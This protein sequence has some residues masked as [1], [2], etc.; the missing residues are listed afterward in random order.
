MQRVIEKTKK[1]SVLIMIATVALVVG[2]TAVSFYAS[3]AE[4]VVEKPVGVIGGDL[5]A[6]AALGWEYVT[7]SY[8]GVGVMDMSGWS[9][10][11]DDAAV[12]TFENFTLPSGASVRVCEDMAAQG[13]D[14]ALQWSAGAQFDDVTGSMTLRNELGDTVFAIRYE[15]ITD[16]TKSPIKGQIDGQY[17]VEVLG[18]SDKVKLCHDDTRKG[19]VEKQVTSGTFISKYLGGKNGHH[20]DENDIIPS[21][22]HEKKGVVGYYG[23]MNYNGNEIFLSNGCM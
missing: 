11:A 20:N 23:G 17:V 18:S 3:S 16:D 22:F 13:S 4:A 5:N 14:C 19:F 10:Y 1:H 6:R 9:I 15:D 2:V 8:N 21:F 12:F 7:I